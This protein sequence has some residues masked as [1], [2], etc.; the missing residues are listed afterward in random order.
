MG[1]QPL[2]S[3]LEAWR[4]VSLPHTHM[5]CS[6][7]FKKIKKEVI[8][9]FPTTPSALWVKASSTKWMFTAGRGGGPSEQHVPW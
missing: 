8:A 9:V 2:R 4:G 6:R 5:Q 1:V 7:A 3:G